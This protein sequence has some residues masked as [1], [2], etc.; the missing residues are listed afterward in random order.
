MEV[1]DQLAQGKGS[2]AADLV[3][4]RV[5]ALEQSVQ[6]GNTWKKAKFLE[7]VAEESGLADKGEEQMMMKEA[8]LE[9]K[10]KSRAAWSP[11]WEEGGAAP[12]GKGGREG[13]RGKGKNKGKNKTPAQEAA[14]TK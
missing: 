10:F 6:D 14:E 3:A 12:K 9:D 8:E 2:T 1:L 4:Q 5:K 13:D 11:R 7:L